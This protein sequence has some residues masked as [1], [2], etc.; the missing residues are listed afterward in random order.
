MGTV[1]MQVW[2]ECLCIAVERTRG[3][4]KH[5][6]TEAVADDVVLDPCDGLETYLA[7]AGTRVQTPHHE[8]GCRKETTH[9]DRSRERTRIETAVV[10]IH[11]GQELGDRE[12]FFVGFGEI[13]GRGIVEGSFEIPGIVKSTCQHDLLM[14]GPREVAFPT[15]TESF[16]NGASLIGGIIHPIASGRGQYRGFRLTY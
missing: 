16:D 8:R 11:N 7:S 15:Y 2:H 3:L 5:A 10:P 12:C 14:S 4:L 1:R 6:W 9:Q 13:G